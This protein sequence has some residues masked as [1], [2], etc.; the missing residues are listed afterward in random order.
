[1]FPKIFENYPK[2]VRSSYEHFRS[3]FENFRKFPK[4]TER[5]RI[6]PSNLRRCFD[7]IEINLG[8]FNTIN[9]VNLTAHMTSLI[10]SIETVQAYLKALQFELI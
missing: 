8:S 10:S 2:T 4:I 5:C 1:M 6:F 3:F 7:H 9:L